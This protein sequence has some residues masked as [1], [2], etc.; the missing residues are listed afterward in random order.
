M[1]A[2]G[3]NQSLFPMSE[4]SVMGISEV[5]TKILPLK[6]GQVAA[7]IVLTIN[8]FLEATGTT[9][10]FYRRNQPR[11]NSHHRFKGI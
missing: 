3:M 10:Q 7:R 5:I 9:L 6:V 8:F 4:L 11:F 1:L 2:R